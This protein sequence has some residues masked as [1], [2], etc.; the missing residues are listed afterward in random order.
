MNCELCTDFRVFPEPS[1]PA[2][3]H[4]A[5]ECLAEDAAIH[6]A[7][8]LAPVYEDDGHLLDAETDFVGSELHF[9]LEGIAFETDLIEFDGL[10]HAPF[11]AFET[12]VSC[13]LNPVMRRTYFEAK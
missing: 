2:Q 10:Q 8:A 6:L 12:L 4:H 3:S 5:E 13:T 1:V 9:D 11:V 7:H